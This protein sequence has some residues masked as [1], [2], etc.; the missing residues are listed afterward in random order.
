VL[1]AAA[2][3]AG[4]TI[5]MVDATKFGRASLVSVLPVGELDVLISDVGLED[6]V[7]AAYR[8]AGVALRLAAAAG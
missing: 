8:A 4:R 1:Q 5:G 2:D 6:D 7:A 3:V